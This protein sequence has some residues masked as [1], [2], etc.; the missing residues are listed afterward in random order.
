[1]YRLD[2]LWVNGVIRRNCGKHSGVVRLDKA[3]FMYVALPKLFWS[4]TELV[5][6]G[7]SPKLHMAS[8]EVRCGAN[9]KDCRRELAVLTTPA[10]E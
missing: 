7:A 10:S 3:S 1:M 6:R 8:I 2:L 4:V 5:G 9:K